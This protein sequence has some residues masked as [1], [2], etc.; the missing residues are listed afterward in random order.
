MNLSLQVAPPAR[1][2]EPGGHADRRR[3]H[4]Q[5]R[6]PRH[7]RHQQGTLATGR[8]GLLPEGPLLS[9]ERLAHPDPR[10][11]A[12]DHPISFSSSSTCCMPWASVSR[13]KRAVAGLI[14]AYPWPGN[15][16]ELKNVAEYLAYLDKDTIEAKD[17][18]PV[19]RWPASARPVGRQGDRGHPRDFRPRSSTLQVFARA[20]P[21][22]PQAEDPDGA[23]D[24]CV[25]RRWSGICS[26]Q[27]RRSGNCWSS[28][29][30]KAWFECPTGRGGTVISPS[31][32]EFLKQIA[33]A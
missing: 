23:A 3:H 29:K 12:K 31:G 33:N 20:P 16:R 11:C 21:R 32:I 15:V 27:R 24:P 5:R 18:M 14:Q 8:G 9:I 17:L 28:W 26:S 1:A 7:R 4:D 19:L 6:Y 25:S 22:R 13:W 2:R 30:L 10:P